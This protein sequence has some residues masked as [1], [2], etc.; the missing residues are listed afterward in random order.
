MRSAARSTSS[1]SARTFPSSRH[2]VHGKP[3]V[4]LDNAATTQKP[5]AVIDA[6][7][8]LLRGGE[9][10]H[11]PR[12]APPERARDA[13]TRRRASACAVHQ[14][15][16]DRAR[17]S[18]RA[19]PPRRSTS[20]RRLG[21][22]R[23]LRAGDEILISAMEHHS[24]IVPWQM[25]REET[26]ATLRGRPDRRR[27]ELDV[28]EFEQ[29]LSAEGRGS[30]RS[31]HVS[32]ALGTINPVR[33]DRRA[34]ARARRPGAGRRRAGGR[35]CRSTC[36][37]LDC[38]FYAFSGHKMYGPTGIG[39]LYGKRRCSRRCRRTRAAAT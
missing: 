5:Q 7:V 2:G 39:V 21:D 13:R 9:R 22:A 20:W 27:G 24:N 18:S 36:R 10:Q 26:G 1:A 6:L 32:N 29:L 31:R 8:R 23:Q 11:P 14:R 28:D 33:R 25:L 3:L 15:A 19:A 4:Y 35:T 12:R 34:G 38:D 37:T 30:S 16:A 17:S